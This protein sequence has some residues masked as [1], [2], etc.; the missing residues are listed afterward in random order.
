LQHINNLAW[1]NDT[2]LAIRHIYLQDPHLSTFRDKNIAFQ[3]GIEKLMPTK[4]IAAMN[5]P[6]R[7]DSVQIKDGSIDVHEVSAATNKE[8]VVQL[9]NLNATLKKIVSRPKDHDSLVLEVMGRVLGYN[10]RA[11]RYAESYHDSLSGFTMHYGVSPMQ[12]I[13]LTAVTNPLSAVAITNGQADTL[14]AR[15]SG[16]K[17]AASGEIDFYYHNLKVRLLNKE[18][19]LKKSLLLT[20]KTLLANGLIRSNNTRQARLFFI[21]DRERFVFNYWVKTLF[22]GFITSAGLKRNSTYEKLYKEAAKK[23]SMPAVN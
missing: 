3:H 6:V 15:L 20:L 19:T 12:L 8:G 10:I 17:Y 2:V 21:R 22:S 23:Y 4:L 14:Y 18:D 7:I 13:H 5:I 16:N 11:F 1:L 9:R